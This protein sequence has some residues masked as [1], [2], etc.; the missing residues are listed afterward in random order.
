M[1]ILEM[2]IVKTREI[3]PAEHFSSRS[4]NLELI[5]LEMIFGIGSYTTSGIYLSKLSAPL[6][7]SY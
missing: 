3:A 6:P 4:R 7:S 2:K 1:V 5:Y